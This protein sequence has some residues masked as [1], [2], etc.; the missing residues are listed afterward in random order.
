VARALL[1]TVFAEARRR[2]LARVALTV[3]GESPTGAT[4]LYRGEGM[5]VDFAMRVL[6]RP[7]QLA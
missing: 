6:Q 7:V 3:D 1:R 4:A 2:G 5:E